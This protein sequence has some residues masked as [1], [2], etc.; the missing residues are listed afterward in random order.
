MSTEISAQANE[1]NRDRIELVKR[2]F[3]KG[4]TDDELN[5]FIATCKRLGL[6]PEARQIFAVKRWDNQEKKMIMSIQTS[7]DGH[8]LVA[9]RTGQYEGQTDPE[10]CGEDG[11]WR[12]VWLNQTS[13]KA[14]RVGVYKKGFRNPIY[15]TAHWEEFCQINKEGAPTAMWRK[16]PRLMLAKCAESSALRK[17]F[18]NE[19]SAVYTSDEFPIEAELAQTHLA[20]ANQRIEAKSDLSVAIYVHSAESSKGLQKVIKNHFGKDFE[21][22]LL[23]FASH[24]LNGKEYIKDNIAKAIEIA[25][26]QLFLLEQEADNRHSQQPMENL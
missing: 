9:E 26:E 21:N 18:P 3:C 19:L 10:W 5:L 6:S 16:M 23:D 4:A 14:A 17:A 15:S 22:S 1:W 24:A 12:N 25:E 20:Q 11:V 8:R 2:T 13:P 7:I